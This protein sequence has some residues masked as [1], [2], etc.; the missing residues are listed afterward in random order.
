MSTPQ[1]DRIERATV[2]LDAYRDCTGLDDREAIS[3]LLADLM[4]LVDHIWGDLDQPN[5]EDLLD[6]AEMHYQEEVEGE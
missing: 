4:H 3:D 6:T 5:F 2:A 1:E